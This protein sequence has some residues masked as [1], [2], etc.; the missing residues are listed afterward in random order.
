MPDELTF[1]STPVKHCRSQSVR[2]RNIGNAVANV[3]FDTAFIL[4]HVFPGFSSEKCIKLKNTSLVPINFTIRIIAPKSETDELPEISK[5]DPSQL[6][7]QTMA[8]EP[9]SQP[10]LPGTESETWSTGPDDMDE[11][12]IQ[13]SSGS[14][15]AM[16]QV[17]LLVRCTPKHLGMHT[18]TIAIDI[19]GVGI[20]DITL[21]VKVTLKTR[22]LLGAHML[23]IPHFDIHSPSINTDSIFRAEPKAGVIPAL[24]QLDLIVLAQPDDVCT[25]KDQME[26]VVAD[27][28][29]TR[30]IELTAVGQGSTIVTDPPLLATLRL[31][32]HFS[33]APLR[34][35]FKLT[36]KGRRQQQLIWSIDGQT[37]RRP[38]QL[39]TKVIITFINTDSIFRAEPKAGVIPALGQLDLI[40]LAQP[41][42]VCTFKDQMEIVVADAVS[43]RLIELTAVGQGS[44]IVTDPPLLATL[45][46]GPHFSMAPLRTTFKLTSKGR[47]QQQLIWSID[48]Q[49]ARRPSQ[50]TT[51]PS[52]EDSRWVITPYRFDI[53][54]GEST[55]VTLEV[56]CDKPQV[57]KRRIFCHTIIGRKGAKTLIKTVDISVNFVTPN[58]EFSQQELI[59]RVIK[60]VIRLVGEVHFPNI[61]FDSNAVHFGYILNHTEITKHLLMTNTSP[62]PV[63]FRWSFLVGERANIVFRRQTRL[64]DSPLATTQRDREPIS[65]TER[66]SAKLGSVTDGGNE[67]QWKS[68]QTQE[69]LMTEAEPPSVS[70]G[71]E[72]VSE[73]NE[74]ILPEEQKIIKDSEFLAIQQESAPVETYTTSDPTD[75][76]VEKNEVL[77]CLIEQDNDVIPLGIEEIFDITPLYGELAAGE[78]QSMSFV[79][80]GHADIEASITAVCEVEGGPTYTMEI[81]GGASYIDY[82]LDRTEIDF[83]PVRFDKPAVSELLLANIGQVDFEFSITPSDLS[84]EIRETVL[85][86]S[87]YAAFETGQLVAEPAVGDL[88][89]GET[90]TI[91][92]SYLARKPGF[93]EKSIQLYVA[94][95]PPKLIVLRGLADFARL[96]LDLPRYYVHKK[97]FKVPIQTALENSF[98]DVSGQRREQTGPLGSDTFDC[99]VLNGPLIPVWL[100][101]EVV[102]PVLNAHVDCLEFGVVQRGEARL[103]PVQLYNP[104][105]VCVNWIHARHDKT[106]GRSTANQP[107]CIGRRAGTKS[108]RFRIDNHPPP[109]FEVI[110][111]SGS[112]GAGEKRNIQEDQILRKLGSFDE[113]GL[114]Y[115]PPRKPGESL[116]PELTS[117]YEEY[118]RKLQESKDPL[119]NVEITIKDDILSRYEMKSSN[120]ELTGSATPT[121]KTDNDGRSTPTEILVAT[122]NNGTSRV[123]EESRMSTNVV[124]KD[125]TPISLALARHLG[126]NINPDGQ[127][128]A[129][130][131]GIFII[132]HGPLAV[133][134]QPV[135]RDLS[136]RYQATVLSVDQIVLEAL[137]TSSTDAAE[138]A[139]QC[140]LQSGYEMV[141]NIVAKELMERIAEADAKDEGFE[142]SSETSAGNLIV[143]I[144]LPILVI[145][146]QPNQAGLSGN[147]ASQQ[148]NLNVI[149]GLTEPSLSPTSRAVT[150][151]LHAANTG[152][153]PS[154]LPERMTD[155]RPTSPLPLGPPIPRRISLTGIMRTGAP[156]ISFAHPISEETEEKRPLI[157]SAKN[158]MFSTIL[159]DDVVVSLIEERICYDDCHKGV[160]LDG[161][162]SQF[163]ENRQKVGQLV[164]KALHDRLYIY[165]VTVKA[166]YSSLKYLEEQMEA[167]QVANKMA[168]EAVRQQRVEEISEFEY[169]LLSE[170][171]RAQLDE[172]RTRARRQKRQAEMEHKRIK[173]EQEREEH[174]TEIRRLKYERDSVSKKKGKKGDDKLTQPVPSAKDGVERLGGAPTRTL[175]QRAK[176]IRSEHLES[177]LPEKQHL[178]SVDRRRMSKIPDKRRKSGGDSLKDEAIRE[179][180]EEPEMTEEEKLLYQRFKTFVLEL[181]GICDL[182]SCWDRVTLSK[183]SSGMD[184]HEDTSG[185]PATQST[186]KHRG[187]GQPAG[188]VASGAPKTRRST[189]KVE[190]G[191]T[192]STQNLDHAQGHVSP[193]LPTYCDHTAPQDIHPERELEQTTPTSELYSVSSKKS[194]T[195][196]V[197]HLIVD[198]QL[199]CIPNVMQANA[200][201]IL[202]VI[203]TCLMNR[204]RDSP[205]TL[206][207]RAVLFKTFVLELA[208]ICDLFSCW[209]RVTLSKSS[210]GMDGHE[211]TSGSPATQSTKKHRGGGQPAGTVASGAP[212]TRRSTQKV[213]GGSTESTQNLDHAQGHVSP[214]LP[215]YCDHTAPQDI[216]PERELEQTTPTSEL[217]SV[218]SKKSL[219]YGVPHLIVDAQLQCIP[220]VM[221]DFRKEVTTLQAQMETIRPFQT[222]LRDAWSEEKLVFK[223]KPTMDDYEP[224]AMLL[225]HLP[226]PEEI[227][228][229]LGL[230][231]KGPPLPVPANL[232]VIRY[233]PK[234]PIPFRYLTDSD[235]LVSG[236]KSFKKN[237]VPL[238]IQSDP[239]YKNVQYF[240]FLPSGVGDPTTADGKHGE[241]SIS[242]AEE[243]APLSTT[244]SLL[245]TEVIFFLDTQPN[246]TNRPLTHFRWIIPAHGQVQLR[247]RFR[248]DR[249][250]QFDQVFHFELLGSRRE[251]QLYCRGTCA[252]PTISREPR[253]I[254]SNRKRALQFGEIIQKTYIMETETFEFGPLLVEK[255]R[256]KK[257]VRSITLRNST[258]LPVLWKLA[259]VDALG[260][261]FSVPQDA[262]LVEPKSDFVLYAYF[263]AMKPFKSGQKKN[264]RL[265]VYD[266]ENLAGMIQAET[267]Q[268]IAEAYDVALDISFPK[269]SDGGI[270]FGMV[271]VGEEVKQSISLKNKGPYEITANKNTDQPMKLFSFQFERPKKS[272]VNPSDVFTITPHRQNITPTEKAAAVTVSRFTI[273]PSKGINFG[274][275][276]VQHRKTRQ[277]VIENNGEQEFRFSI[278][279]MSKMIEVVTAKEMGLQKAKQNLPSKL[280]IGIRSAI[281][282]EY[283]IF[284][285]LK[286]ILP[287]IETTDIATIFEE[288]RICNDLT[289][290]KPIELVD[291]GSYGCGVYG[292]AENCFLF[293]NV[294]VGSRVRARFCIANRG[295]VPAEV[296]FELRSTGL[297]PSQSPS[298]PSGQSSRSLTP[299]DAFEVDPEREQIEPHTC[300]Y[301]NVT[302]SPSAMHKYAAQFRVY[303]ENM[304]SMGSTGSGRISYTPGGSKLTTA[305]PVLS[306]ELAGE[307]HLPRLTV[308]EPTARSRQGHVMCVFQRVQLGRQANRSLVLKNTG[309][310]N[311]RVSYELI[312]PP[313]HVYSMFIH[314]LLHEL[315]P[316]R[317]LP[318]N[319]ATDLAPR[320]VSSATEQHSVAS[321][322]NTAGLLLQPG[323]QFCFRVCYRPNQSGLKSLGQIRLL[324]VN[325]PYEDTLVE[326]V[327]ESL[328]DEVCLYDLPQLEPERARCIKEALIRCSSASKGAGDSS[329]QDGAESESAWDEVQ[330][331]AGAYV[332]AEN[333][334]AFRL[335]SFFTLVL[336]RDVCKLDHLEESY[337]DPLRHN[338]LDFGDCAPSEPVSYTFTFTHCGKLDNMEPTSF[339]YVWPTDHPNLQFQP[340]EGHLHPNQSRRITVTFCASNGPVTL[341]AS[342]IKC[343]LRR[344]RLPIPEGCTKPADWDDTKQ[345]IR[346]VD[347]PLDP[348]KQVPVGPDGMA[349]STSGSRTNSRLTLTSREGHHESPTENSDVPNSDYGCA[350]EVIRK[351]QKLIEVE[352]EPQFEEIVDR[353]EPKPLELL[354]SV[355]SDYARFNC[356]VDCIIFKETLMLQRRIYR[357]ELSN[358]GL[359][360]LNYRWVIEMIY[361]KDTGP[362]SN[363]SNSDATDLMVSATTQDSDDGLPPFS[364][365]PNQGSLLPGKLVHIEVT[366]S[367]LS[368]GKFEARLRGLF[369]NMPDPGTLGVKDRGSGKATQLITLEGVAKQPFI[370]FDLHESDY[371]TAG[372][373]NPELPGPAGTPIGVPLDSLTRV[374][375]LQTVGIGNKT[376]K[377]F[378][379]VNLTTM[380]LHFVIDNEDLRS[381][382]DHQTIT[383]VTNRGHIASG[384][385][386]ELCFE[387]RAHNVGI[388]ESFWRLKFEQLQFSVP[389]LVVAHVREPDI[390]FDRSSIN[391]RAVLV[392]HTVNQTVYLCNCEPDSEL[393]SEPLEFV[394]LDSSRYG[395]GRQDV[396][397][398]EPISGQ[399]YPNKPFPIQV[400]FTAK[401]ERLTNVNLVCH[402]KFRKS[403]LTLNVKAEGYTM[404][405]TVWAEKGDNQ[406]NLYEVSPLWSPCLGVDV[407]QLAM[408]VGQRV[409]ATPLKYQPLLDKL[410]FGV[411]DPG[412]C[413]TRSLTLINCGKFKCDFAWHLT[414]L[415]SNKLTCINPE[416]GSD[417][418]QLQK[419]GELFSGGIDQD[420]HSIVSISPEEGC[421]HPGDKVICTATFA[422]PKQ[423]RQFGPHRVILDG[424]VVA[425]LA[426]RE[427]PAFGLELHGRTS[428]RVVCFSSSVIDFGAQL[429]SRPGL[430][431]ACR[432]LQLSN[433][434]PTVL[435]AWSVS[436]RILQYSSIAWCPPYCKRNQ[437]NQKRNRRTIRF[438]YG[439]RLHLKRAR[440]MKKSWCLK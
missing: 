407:R 117:S 173:G 364:V 40:V 354:V 124:A 123:G 284:Y 90:C 167:T 44:T 164:L 249:I 401:A 57:V 390:V 234:R 104:S 370:H 240:H 277:I 437:L 319:A 145:T 357:F 20:G 420:M 47:R 159:P 253:L 171:E 232:A 216:H 41:D 114:M 263:R 177:T 306:F 417:S 99:Y 209:D 382:K 396:V 19:I 372:R 285:K 402:V 130:R 438:V 126:I 128:F 381:P 75:V 410:D 325:N 276:V 403:A 266:V 63:I 368:V 272:K 202:K 10:S 315:R 2:I 227:L 102:I 251:Y 292:V 311:S 88:A 239:V 340:S 361:T 69:K 45:R 14:L 194:L 212:K 119:E 386:T 121:D 92:L 260:E 338:H 233:P 258:L 247:I 94:H 210:S 252:S 179:Q 274:A 97:C 431:P 165:C 217:Y 30:L 238:T 134:R 317:I 246:S 356:D 73:K 326:L 175:H 87:L 76:L 425:C 314:C 156:M 65:D 116:P 52:D 211:D 176:S 389:L 349:R 262:G 379:V 122:F 375:E 245:P 405:V 43:T 9:D 243:Q 56:T 27:A 294:L 155:V 91:R 143:A 320:R 362:I 26:I 59:F 254:Y 120:P 51:K 429:V 428:G 71:P 406:T 224:T 261:E 49:T 280:V 288:H 231:N 321:Q 244:T 291:K 434:D 191:S 339:R 440:S 66:T 350:A 416:E 162:D 160:I 166:E 218:S 435:S 62:L 28:V 404:S 383:C 397:V 109:I 54:P 408:Q 257:D 204:T 55:E 188:T 132:V 342:P 228:D 395:P 215:T 334:N 110:P 222:N 343:V 185:S 223:T 351:K 264:L 301:V 391:F 86:E 68:R 214:L 281:G 323:K 289:L 433:T 17:E 168:D 21:P 259:G 347:A 139:R 78:T 300:T 192:E 12:T 46:L 34:T 42:D 157:D 31:G 193:L 195:Y 371:L 83:D 268:V 142:C 359:V 221:Q 366:F 39:T 89:A 365:R 426:F 13:P 226:D 341:Q 328:A 307:G 50:L 205:S 161:L 346:W 270:D 60:D 125:V 380:D 310:L 219:T 111:K 79:F 421:L 296:L 158:T 275:V 93:F 184:G 37:A 250:G 255:T 170:Q 24:G 273:A 358:T 196:G 16:S 388:F 355:V 151:K 103:L 180:M 333:C 236:P 430:L 187:G 415:K 154:V 287:S 108:L 432:Q 64:P 200:E 148:L 85:E 235:E 377:R 197:P 418:T 61:K 399:A 282:M 112:L 7:L 237:M 140:C 138:R 149:Q 286:V 302:F 107:T 373:R 172:I 419:S 4:L 295:R 348:S 53:N 115:L 182:F 98:G 256:E 392:G 36:S 220:N 178:L 82:Y 183:S 336:P 35:T 169:S 322:L 80:Y 327:G 129:S 199:Q 411:V 269:S 77:S 305:V 118:L 144:L 278:V 206:T 299:A 95:F 11:F 387:A 152:R 96:N 313:V 398:V 384:K 163:V 248:A 23:L 67:M 133:V 400:S 297:I 308:L 203:L 345:M 424:L 22:K 147:L 8:I 318:T 352:P 423:M 135:I 229:Y 174:E 337:S 150:A 413:I 439:S 335:T 70:D 298:R 241:A 141:P 1:D 242:L 230:G 131:C 105:P 32:P 304:P 436:H 394:F 25:F 146:G 213:E 353:P 153:R 136:K 412:E 409:K 81:S 3:K 309:I 113:F 271:R 101:A 58:I 38:S 18:Y 414:K 225:A 72:E 100:Q 393:D 427:G 369:D 376:S 367:P 208:G 330:T 290:L 360:T 198:A 279:R 344:I 181:A 363:G 106:V 378:T 374:V 201:N 84:T 324:V 422:P 127:L 137:A 312:T 74:S 6:V 29:S 48:G 33:M 190:G 293:T 316:T 329:K 265:E 15:N 385:Q 189:Q 332:L 303:L 331:I 267:I 5:P 207:L 283:H 186:K